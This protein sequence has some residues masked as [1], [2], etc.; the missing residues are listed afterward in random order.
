MNKKLLTVACYASLSWLAGS[1]AVS[2]A[3]IHFQRVR[4]KCCIRPY[5][6]GHD[7][8][9]SRDTVVAIAD[10]TRDIIWLNEGTQ[11]VEGVNREVLV[12]KTVRQKPFHFPAL[13]LTAGPITLDRVGL[14]IYNTGDIEAT[15][16][17]SH[18]GGPDGGLLGGNGTIRL[19]AYT[20]RPGNRAEPA[21]SPVVWGSECHFWVSANR[22]S[23]IHLTP[24]ECPDTS[25]IRRQFNQITHLEVE[26]E[27]QGDR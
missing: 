1:A 16:R 17:I 3:E 11:T 5:R 23:V 6:Y 10:P 18:D 22:P 4:T 8:L 12:E 27:Y 24:V 21:D 26:L 7:S 9:R 20:G 25:V 15:G 13:S 19:H 14:R 2:L